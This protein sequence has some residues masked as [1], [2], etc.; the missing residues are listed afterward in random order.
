MNVNVHV[1]VHV[2]V[3]VN[4][5]VDMNTNVNMDV[6]VN[7]NGNANE[8]WR[9]TRHVAPAPNNLRLAPQLPQYDQTTPTNHQE[10]SNMQSQI[11]NAQACR[12][13]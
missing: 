12:L 6:N 8:G 13:F 9:T 1:H 7:V 3:N 10:M 4:V 11:E 2:N 5:K